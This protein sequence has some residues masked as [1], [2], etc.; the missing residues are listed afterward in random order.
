MRSRHVGREAGYLLVT[1]AVVLLGIPLL[2]FL[3]ISLFQSSREGWSNATGFVADTIG[4]LAV[5]R[6]SSWA[7]LLG[8]YL[9]FTGLRT[10]LFSWR[11]YR[12]KT[13]SRRVERAH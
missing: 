2:I 4:G 5:G 13:R 8:P 7:L 9:V 12:A 6:M 1:W 10:L 11:R 3:S